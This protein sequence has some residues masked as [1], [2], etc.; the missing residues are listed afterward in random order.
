MIRELSS[1]FRN[2]PF[3]H[4]VH[5]ETLLAIT[6]K[7][8]NRCP[9][10]Y[11]ISIKGYNFDFGFDISNKAKINAEKAIKEVERICMNWQLQ[12]R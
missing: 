11:L 1:N 4:H 6:E 9:K 8:Y 10:A 12:K 5:P 2:T 7:L 3:S